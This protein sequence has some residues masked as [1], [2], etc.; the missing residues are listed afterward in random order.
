MLYNPSGDMNLRDITEK[1][2]E[3]VSKEQ[4]TRILDRYVWAANHAM[5]ADVLEIACGTGQG[6]TLISERAKSLTFLDASPGNIADLKGEFGDTVRVSLG[7]AEELPFPDA[8]FDVVLMLECLYFFDDTEKALAEARRVLRPN[9][10]LLVTVN[11]KDIYDFTRHPMGRTYFG[12]PDL[13]STLAAFGFQVE[14]FGNCPIEGSLVSRVKTGI[15][16]AVTSLGLF[17][18]SPVVK[19]IL[20][21]LF[22]GK[23]L[24]MPRRLYSNGH[25]TPELVALKPNTTDTRYKILF[26]LCKMPIEAKAQ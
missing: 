25:A 3:L 15:K 9:G 24:E 7:V 12:V 21:R 5:N 1:A 11:N 18:Q 26:A 13:H 10:L 4:Y 16:F 2:G 23:L 6:A 8:M 17:P 14:I 19:R 20:K 22:F